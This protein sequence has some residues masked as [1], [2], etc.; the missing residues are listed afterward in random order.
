VD[1]ETGMEIVMSFRALHTA[2]DENVLGTCTSYLTLTPASEAIGIVV[3]FHMKSMRI[4]AIQQSVHVAST[5]LRLSSC[6]SHHFLGFSVV[7]L[8][9]ASGVILDF[10]T[11][12]KLK[13]VHLGIQLSPV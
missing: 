2:I 12:W 10:C 3:S 13:S 6:Y 8:D 4:E 11:V 9:H 5:G 1:V 7:D